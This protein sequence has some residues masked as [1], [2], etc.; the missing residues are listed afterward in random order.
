VYVKNKQ[1]FPA[2]VRYGDIVYGLPLPAGCCRAV[3]AS[4]ILEHLPLDDCRAALGN[5]YKLLM[6]GGIFRLIVPDLEIMARTYLQ[7]QEIDACEKFLHATALGRTARPRGPVGF[8]KAY[9]GNSDHLWMWDFKSMSRELDSFG[10]T[11]IR[12][13]KP[14]DSE[15]PMFSDVENPERF[16]EAVAIECRKPLG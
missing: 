15:D 5:T 8:I 4:H 6:P 12:Q 3:Y 13:C 7:S 1:R 9:L 11:A 14:G 10:F 2:N 16:F